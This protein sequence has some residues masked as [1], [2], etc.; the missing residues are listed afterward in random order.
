[1]FDRTGDGRSLSLP[2]LGAWNTQRAAG[3]PYTFSFR[4]SVFSP[5]PRARAV[6]ARLPS[7]RSSVARMWRRS[8]QGLAARDPS[9]RRSQLEPRTSSRRPARF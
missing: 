7:K 9:I 5:M 6:A 8:S 3:T 4:Q 2:K 1:M